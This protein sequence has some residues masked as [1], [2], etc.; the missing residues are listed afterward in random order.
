M[1]PAVIARLAAVSAAV[2]IGAGAFGAHAA[3]GRAVEWLHT[4]AMYQL[5]HAVAVIV[6]LPRN[7]AAAMLMLAGATV[8]AFSLYAMALGAPR[9]FGAITPLGGVAMI[10]GWLWLAAARMRG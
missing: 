4:G 3:Q 2:A 6:L 9:W 5:I 7:R 1:T 10:A 8:F